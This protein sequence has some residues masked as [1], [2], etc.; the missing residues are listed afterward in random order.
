MSYNVG[1]A[2]YL[3]QDIYSN[4]ANGYST[5]AHKLLI[6]EVHTITYS[7]GTQIFYGI[8]L[9]GVEHSTLRLVNEI[10]VTDKSEE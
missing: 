10:E 3:K 2:I 4:K 6:V 5:K 9:H 1:D 7:G 8:R